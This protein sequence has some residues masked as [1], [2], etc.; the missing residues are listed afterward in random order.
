M[1]HDDEKRA[2]LD[3][4]MRRLYEVIS[5]PEGETPDW[6]AMREIFA[7]WARMTRITPEGVD[8]LDLSG[9]EA[10]FMEMLEAGAVSAFF[11]YEV[12][13]RTEMF[14]AVA[15]VLSA[16][17]T[18]RSPQARSAFGRGINSLQLLWDGARWSIAGLLWDERLP[19][20]STAFEPMELIYD[21]AA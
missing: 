21:P 14:G 18:K 13:R 8:A 2:G 15:H 4:I 6:S 19:R 9:F 16:Y 5:F 17:E 12:S 11:E 20:L 10:M 1:S 7:P 3:A